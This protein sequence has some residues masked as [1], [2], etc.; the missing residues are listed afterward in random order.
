MNKPV[1]SL[2]NKCAV[3]CIIGILYLAAA[4][5]YFI[6]YK[7][8]NSQQRIIFLMM[9]LLFL[10]AFFVCVVFD[11][12]S[13]IK[14][15]QEDEDEN[16]KYY[17]YRGDMLSK[18]VI[19][20]LFIVIGMTWWLAKPDYIFSLTNTDFCVFGLSVYSVQSIVSNAYF[21]LMDHVAEDEE[22]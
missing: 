13:K 20:F 11:V 15:K 14:F 8:I 9:W 7:V 12:V 4:V 19:I 6:V 1:L 10:I 22:E 2:R 16:A 3:S 5:L 18:I 17:M 21:L